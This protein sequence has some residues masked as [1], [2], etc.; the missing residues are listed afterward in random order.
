MQRHYF[1]DDDLDD[2]ETVSE[3]LE[4]AG[5][6]GEQIY[7]LTHNEEEV[8]RRN[9][10]HV[11]SVLKKDT[12][13]AALLGALIG[14]CL[15]AAVL[16]GA[17]ASGLPQTYSWAPFTFLAI[18]L[19]GFSTWEGGLWGIQEP[20][21]EFK[22]FEAELDRGRHVLLVEADSKQLAAVNTVCGA[23]PG[24]NKIGEGKSVPKVLRMPHILFNRYRR[25]GP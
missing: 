25:W 13:R 7:V 16:A 3:E 2:L 10:N 4:D 14:V 5:I 9:F 23:H 20:H 6:A 21:H 19:L 17:W 1:V 22:R 24:L 15:A 12:V 18:I 11:W 8:D